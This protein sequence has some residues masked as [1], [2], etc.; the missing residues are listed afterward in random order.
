M[1]NRAQGALE[2]LLLIGG[3]IVIAVLVITI[4]SGLSNTGANTAQSQ[5]NRFGN[6]LENIAPES[7]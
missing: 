5:M 4:V 3:A 2:Y 6:F 7:G 1:D